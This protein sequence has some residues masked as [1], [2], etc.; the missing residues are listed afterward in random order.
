MHTVSRSSDQR[1]TSPPHLGQ[2]AM[3]SGDARMNSVEAVF[4]LCFD[5]FSFI[6]LPPSFPGK[7][8]HPGIP[9]VP[10]FL[11]VALAVRLGELDQRL[12]LPDGIN[13]VRGSHSS[14][15][16]VPLVKHELGRHLIGRRDRSQHK[17]RYVHV[18][19]DEPSVVCKH[20]CGIMGDAL[21]TCRA[22]EPGYD[23]EGQD[24]ITEVKTRVVLST[25][26]VDAMIYAHERP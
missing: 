21:R 4:S 26:T 6:C 8:F 20:G 15:G 2:C 5:G 16:A 18:E 24:L 23:L 10:D 1:P 17:A 14:P 22:V 7:T 25:G 9:P 19:P 11:K 13:V 3:M 12:P